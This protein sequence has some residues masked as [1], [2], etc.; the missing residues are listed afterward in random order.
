MCPYYFADVN[1]GS[2]PE[3]LKTMYSVQAAEMCIIRR[4]LK[5]IVDREENKLRSF[6]NGIHTEMSVVNKN[7]DTW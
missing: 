2:R 4:M 6:K 3:T 1:V 7:Y 5:S